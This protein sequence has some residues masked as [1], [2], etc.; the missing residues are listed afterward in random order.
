[1]DLCFR[2]GKSSAQVLILWCLQ[3]GFMCIPKSVTKERIR[4]NGDVF[5]FNLSA[6]DMG[7]LV[8][9]VFFCGCSLDLLL[10]Y[11]YFY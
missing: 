1:M 11:M 5:D 8:S 7:T 4:Q 6:E 9:L 2:Y 10:N 3:S